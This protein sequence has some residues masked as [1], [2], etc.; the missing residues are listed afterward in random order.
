[1]K[2]LLKIIAIYFAAISTITFSM[3]IME[4]SIQ[5]CTFGTWPAQDAGAWVLV[6][7]NLKKMEKINHTLRQINKYCGWLQPFAY[8][9]YDA[10]ADSTDA[11]IT[12]VRQKIATI[13]PEALIG[14]KITLTFIPSTVEVLH[15]GRL[16]H[17]LGT[18]CI[19]ASTNS[20]SKRK[21]A[22]IP[23]KQEYTTTTG[24]IRKGITDGECKL[25]LSGN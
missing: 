11:Y 8:I 19:T 14:Q 9:A 6:E 25:Y 15:D 2:K 3:F 23:I 5:M 1:M 13:R 20:T 10:Y 21:N 22:K 4:E 24:T 18:L 16:R 7:Q 12:S 17:R